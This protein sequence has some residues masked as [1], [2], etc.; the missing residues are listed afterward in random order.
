MRLNQAATNALT[1]RLEAQKAICDA[2]E[3][4]LHKKFKQRDELEKQI[5][6]EGEHARKR[7]RTDDVLPEDTDHKTLLYLPGIRPRTPLHKELRVFLEEEQ[8][9][10]EA[11]LSANEDAKH[12]EIEEQLTKT[13]IEVIREKSDEHNKSI[14]ALENEISIED[15][16]EALEIGEGRRYK[17]QFPAVQ[18]QETE[19]DEESR[20][21]RGKGNVER[22]LQMLLENS[23]EEMEPETSN[24]HETRTTDEIIT[25]LNQKFPQKGAK[26]SK[27]PG[28]DREEGVTQGF[29]EKQQHIVSEK[30][31]G[32]RVEEVVEIEAN[33]TLIGKGNASG[34]G[35][36]SSKSFE[37][38][39]RTENGKERVLTRSES[40][41]TL[42]R[43]PSSPS[44]ILGMRKGVECMRKKPVVTADDDYNENQG[45]GNSFIKS[46]IKS[47]KKAVKI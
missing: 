29:V 40:A 3:K 46:S 1:A 20:K 17:I 23:Q 30:D 42:R 12:D 21:Q 15:K 45:A 2:S 38:K 27:H 7:S 33:K 44:L 10:S 47:I 19:E 13:A 32:K 5:R 36:G 14:V 4:E 24:G 28:Y 11:G 39:E 9:A 18:E 43:T 25:K 26:T 34:E 35:I 6:P 37:V 22:W 41:R 16:L 8:R 31:K